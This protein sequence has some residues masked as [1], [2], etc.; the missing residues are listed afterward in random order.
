M[1]TLRKRVLAPN[2]QLFIQNAQVWGA[3]NSLGLISK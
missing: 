2:A 1:R 3:L